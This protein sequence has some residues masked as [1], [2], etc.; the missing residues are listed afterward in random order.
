MS[1]AAR[2]DYAEAA[3]VALIDG[4]PGQVHE[5]GGDEAFSMAEYAAAVTA[6]SGTEVAYNDLPAADYAAV[7]EGAGVPGHYA[8]AAGRLR[9]G[10]R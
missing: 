7:L 1:A 4:T 9:P 2:A 6:V 3:A 5:L 8:A 10:P